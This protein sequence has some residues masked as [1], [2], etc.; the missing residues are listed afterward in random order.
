MLLPLCRNKNK[1]IMKLLA[2]VKSVKLRDY[3]QPVEN[4]FL[5]ECKVDKFLEMHNLNTL[6]V[7]VVYKQ[8]KDRLYAKVYVNYPDFNENSSL[9]A[10]L[11]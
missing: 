4:K 8:S 10:L 3:L 5:L 7:D 1:K 2:I 6:N 9:E 11:K